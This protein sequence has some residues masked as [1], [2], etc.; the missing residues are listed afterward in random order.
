[1]RANECVEMVRQTDKETEKLASETNKIDLLD[2][3]AATVQPF[4]NPSQRLVNTA[5]Q[6]CC[7]KMIRADNT[8]CITIMI[9][10]P[11]SYEDYLTNSNETIIRGTNLTTLDINK[12]K[13]L[14]SIIYFI[15]IFIYLYNI[16]G[17]FDFFKF[18]I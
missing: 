9:D 6:R 10:Q 5:M 11:P 13:L 1:M 12:S 2:S 14:L 18:S 15:V 17:C 3:T 8:T 16:Q 7:E 4:V